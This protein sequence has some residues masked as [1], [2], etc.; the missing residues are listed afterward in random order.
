MKNERAGCESMRTKSF[1]KRKYFCI[2]HGVAE[3]TYN[4]IIQN[5]PTSARFAAKGTKK[6]SKSNVK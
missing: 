2:P 3:Q 4:V 6:N 1:S 5:V